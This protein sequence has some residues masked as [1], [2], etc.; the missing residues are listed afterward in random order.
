MVIEWQI[1]GVIEKVVVC[2]IDR[3][4]FLFYDSLRLRITTDTS[5]FDG[6]HEWGAYLFTLVPL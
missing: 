5:D 3:F 1:E 2:L 4:G 6:V